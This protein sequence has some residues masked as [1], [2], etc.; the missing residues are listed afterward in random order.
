MI[1]SYDRLSCSYVN[2]E[3]T[4]YPAGIIHTTSCQL[5]CKH[6]MQILEKLYDT[7]SMRVRELLFDVLFTDAG[8]YDVFIATIRFI[9]VSA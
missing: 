3:P 8:Q 6:R 1:L 9:L 5:I 2:V 4:C 7:S